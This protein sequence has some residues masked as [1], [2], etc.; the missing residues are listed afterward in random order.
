MREIWIWD[1][2][3]LI[4]QLIKFKVCSCIYRICNDRTWGKYEYG[5]ILQLIIQLIHF[6][7]CSCLYTICSD[8]TWGKYEYGTILELIIQ[9]KLFKVCSCIYRICSD[10]TWGKYA[11]KYMYISTYVCTYY[12]CMCAFVCIFIC[13]Y[14][15]QYK[16]FHNTLK[17]IKIYREFIDCLGGTKVPQTLQFCMYSAQCYRE[18]EDVVLFTEEKLNAYCA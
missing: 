5:T 14:A 7:V 2:I 13:V 16:W 12:V 15:L 6:T 9:L 1:N 4:I 17:H 10:R 18:R 8:R 3:Q 11:P